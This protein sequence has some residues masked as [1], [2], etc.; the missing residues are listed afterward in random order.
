MS[1]FDMMDLP[2][3]LVERLNEMGLKDPTPIQKQ[4]I[5][6]ALNGRDV[7]GLAQTGTGKTAAF[8]VPLVAQMLEM[9]QRPSPKSVRGLVLAPTREL[10]QQIMQN[11]KGFCERTPLKVQMVVGGQSINPQISRLAK[12]VDLLVATPGRLLDL[13]DRRAVRLE[14][15]T[16]LVLDEA[17][18][19]L[20]MGFIHDL[21]KI[22]SVIPKER[23]TMLFSA[24]MPKLMNEIANSYLRSPIRIEVSPPGKAADKVTQEVHFI[25]KAEKTNLLIELLAKHRGE[26]ALVFGRTKHGSEKLMKT[27]VK[28][29]FDAASIHGN[30]SQGQRDRAIAGFKSGDV[31]IL[32][33]TDVA[34][35]GLDIPDVKHVYNYDLPNVPDNYVHRIGRTAR[36]G[37]DG[38]AVAFCAPDEM[39]ELKA[40]QKTMGNSIPVASGRPWE[41][42]DAPDKPKGRGRGRGGRPGGGAGG[43]GNRPQ[44]GGG[45]GGAPGKPGAGRRRRRGGGG[46]KPG[47][48][49][50]A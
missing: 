41:A 14:E 49:K 3:K 18:Q 24:T 8:G 34:A 26:R 15:T 1:D 38:A 33:A 44:G 40:I 29:G 6:H 19:M 5:P 4:A 10:A 48:Q 16:F 45:G 22:S 9:A 28:A 17:D 21:R 47:G 42:V 7:M 30:K 20:D 13:M 11:L 50:A 46:G 32:V 23:Q 35:R 39:G 36:A 37:K 25:A 27:L 43:G 12:G 2:P 31:T